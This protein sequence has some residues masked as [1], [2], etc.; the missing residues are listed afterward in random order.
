MSLTLILGGARSGKSA[1]AEYLARLRARD[2]VL[3]I[4]ASDATDRE[5]LDCPGPYRAGRPM[6]WRIIEAPRDVAHI[7]EKEAGQPALVLIDCLA[8][9]ILNVLLHSRKAGQ[10]VTITQNCIDLEVDA[11]LRWHRNSGGSMIV[12]SNEVGMGV[13]PPDD[14]ERLFRQL[15]GRANA[16]IAAVADEV[17]LMVAGLPL[18]IRPRD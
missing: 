5:G 10:S 1:H 14:V 8:V 12:V 17:T 11:L 7:L 13:S 16:R 2:G 15:V 6:T 18:P 9:I 4:S 3:Y